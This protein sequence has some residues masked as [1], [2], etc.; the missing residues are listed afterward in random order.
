MKK[1][2]EEAWATVRRPPWN[3][4]DDVKRERCMQWCWR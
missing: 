4:M 3:L 2:E 1:Y